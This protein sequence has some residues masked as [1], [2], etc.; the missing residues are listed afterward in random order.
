MKRRE[1]KKHKEIVKK[2]GKWK[3]Y[4]N[5]FQ[6]QGNDVPCKLPSSQGLCQSTKQDT[7]L[8]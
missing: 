7:S 8:F 3:T 6:V 4:K 2:K 1:K 5:G